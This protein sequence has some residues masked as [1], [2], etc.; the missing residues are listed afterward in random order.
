M[1]NLCILRHKYRNFRAI[2]LDQNGDMK[3][4]RTREF[5]QNLKQE[6][7]NVEGIQRLD[8]KSRETN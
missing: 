1:Q 3:A 8:L 7:M 6:K 2:Y 5:N 4:E